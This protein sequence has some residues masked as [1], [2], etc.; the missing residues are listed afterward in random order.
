M[1]AVYINSKKAINNSG[2][3]IVNGVG[4]KKEKTSRPYEAVLIARNNEICKIQGFQS[5]TTF[6]YTLNFSNG[7]QYTLKKWDPNSNV[8]EAVD[9]FKTIG[10]MIKNQ[11]LNPMTDR[12]FPKIY[13]VNNNEVGR[14]DILFG[15]SGL[16]SYQ[17]FQVTINGV[18]LT[19]YNVS[20]GLNKNYLAMYN[21][22]NQL[23]GEAKYNFVSSGLDDYTIYSA[24]DDWLKYIFMALFLIC[25]INN[26]DEK[27]NNNS[28]GSLSSEVKDKHNEE[29]IK[30]IIAAEPE[31]NHEEKM[32]LVIEY[33]KQVKKRSNL[34][35]IFVILIFVACFALF[36]IFGNK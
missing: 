30:Q 29:F 27:N 14:I 28:L 33:R 10:S 26:E 36:F 31:E 5:K 16:S 17:Y 4:Y 24:S 15:G 6:D 11:S 13:D 32:P 12:I 23:V 19:V 1:I 18:V 20:I 3:V 35:L 7:E 8:S 25:R 34:A 22:Q 21:A 9:T 2:S